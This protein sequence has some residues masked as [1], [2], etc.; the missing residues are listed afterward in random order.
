MATIINSAAGAQ[1]IEGV[2]S[3]HGLQDGAGAFE[4]TKDGHFSFNFIY[5]ASDRFASGT[6]TIINDTIKLHSD[7]KAG[8]DFTTNLQ[9]HRGGPYTIKIIAPN[10]NLISGVSC[11]YFING[12]GYEAE[13]DSEGMIVLPEQK[14]DTI[15]L[16][17]LYFP[18]VP[19]LIKDLA[20]TNDYFEASMN[21]SLLQVSFKGID[22]FIKEGELTWYANYFLPAENIRFVKE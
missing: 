10:K 11:F 14:V 5:G 15:Y 21:Q 20:N 22:L 1:S 17:H 16:Q 8:E 9:E 12:Q 6:Y 3:M 2:Y 18:D 7:K 13:P 4:F 19:T